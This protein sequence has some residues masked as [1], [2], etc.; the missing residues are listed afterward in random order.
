MTG[1]THTSMATGWLKSGQY[2]PTLTELDVYLPV[3]WIDKTVVT[4]DTNYLNALR[5]RR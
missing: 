2:P 4:L 5:V 3:S 1:V